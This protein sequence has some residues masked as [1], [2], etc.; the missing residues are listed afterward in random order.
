MPFVVRAT[1]IRNHHP[2]QNGVKIVGLG[3]SRPPTPNPKKYQRSFVL[4]F[5]FGVDRGLNPR[6]SHPK[7][8]CTTLS[9]A[10]HP[11]GPHPKGEKR[12]KREEKKV[13]RKKKKRTIS[14]AQISR[15]GEEEEEDEG[16]GEG[17]RARTV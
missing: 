14:R 12:E 13:G 7:C 8:F 6:I 4:F 1:S 17:R 3:N 5:L 15:E 9:L 2:S 10:G 11:S 16:E